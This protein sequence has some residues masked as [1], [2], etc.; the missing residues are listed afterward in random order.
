MHPSHDLCARSSLRMLVQKGQVGVNLLLRIRK[1]MFVVTE[2]NFSGHPGILLDRPS[3][4]WSVPRLLVQHFGKT[5]E[6]G[7]V[8]P[9]G[10]V[11]TRGPGCWQGRRL[12]DGLLG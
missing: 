2:I 11:L 10:H 3:L 1:T 5:F 8:W 6:N 4:M 7:K 9:R 12:C